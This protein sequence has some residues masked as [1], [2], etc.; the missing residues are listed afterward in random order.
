MFAYCE[1][2]PVMGYDP[3]GYW[4]RGEHV[5]MSEK[6]GFKRKNYSVALDWN[7]AADDKPLAS[8]LR[9]R[10]PFH[11]GKKHLELLRNCITIL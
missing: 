6:S 10:S 2:N 4:D 3:E 9:Y 7:Y 5:R 1:D 11:S 8:D